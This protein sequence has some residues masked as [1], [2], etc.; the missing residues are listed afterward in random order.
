MGHYAATV[1]P[2]PIR[3]KQTALNKGRNTER[4]SIHDYPRVGTYI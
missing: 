4:E 3:A 1:V 2:T